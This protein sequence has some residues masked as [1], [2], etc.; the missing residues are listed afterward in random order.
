M[1]Q[2]SNYP[3]GDDENS[4]CAMTIQDVRT[5]LDIVGHCN[6]GSNETL[7]SKE[8]AEKATFKGIGKLEAIPTVSLKV[9]LTKK[10]ETADSHF[11]RA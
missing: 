10:C 5:T 2:P 1:L 8:Y 9:E 6:D 3:S 4:S 11:S 7:A